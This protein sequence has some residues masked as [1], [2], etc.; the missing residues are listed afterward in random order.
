MFTCL[1]TLNLYNV[2]YAFPLYWVDNDSSGEDVGS[3]PSLRDSQNRRHLCRTWTGKDKEA[4]SQHFLLKIPQRLNLLL[5]IY[6]MCSW[7]DSIRNLCFL[8]TKDEKGI[9]SNQ[10]GSER[11][12]A[13][14]QGLGQLL[15]L[16][17]CNPDRVYIGGLDC[18]GR[19]GQFAYSW[20]DESMHGET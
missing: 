6:Y 1:Y 3:H 16:S 2:A 17:E 18:Q 14:V 8:Q 15:R 7:F 10:Y 13:F 4:K 11:Y 9:L 19:D 20:Q 12:A 5:Y